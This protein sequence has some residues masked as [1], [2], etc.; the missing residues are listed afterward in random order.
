MKDLELSPCCREGQVV[1]SRYVRIQC[2]YRSRRASLRQI[3]LD[4]CVNE[5][6]GVLLPRLNQ[7][8]GWIL[9]GCGC[10]CKVVQLQPHVCTDKM[11]SLKL[12]VVAPP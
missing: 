4:Q 6:V 12:L 9:F 3:L 8:C 5:G 11:T 7:L 10:G 1:Q 2:E